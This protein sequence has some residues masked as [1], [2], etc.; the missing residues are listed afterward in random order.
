MP[1][2]EA[3]QNANEGGGTSE[4][5]RPID[6]RSHLTSSGTWS[7]SEIG[8]RINLRSQYTCTHRKLSSPPTSRL[9]KIQ[10]NAENRTSV[11]LA[12]PICKVPLVIHQKFK[13]LIGRSMCVSL[14]LAV[15][16]RPSIHACRVVSCRV[17]LLKPQLQ[18]A[19]DLL[20]SLG[21]VGNPFL[22]FRSVHVPRRL[23]VAIL[24]ALFSFS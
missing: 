16:V 18:F 12:R 8:Q 2:E 21:L 15:H 4:V 6:Q 5:C 1:D 22:I 14:K 9:I 11:Q 13:H 20:L 7:A 24:T 3:L 17:T 23:I 19:L 10:E